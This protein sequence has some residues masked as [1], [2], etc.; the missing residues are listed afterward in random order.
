MNAPDRP[1]MAGRRLPR[2]AGQHLSCDHLFNLGR[3]ETGPV[4]KRL[5]HRAA[6]DRRLHVGQYTPERSKRGSPGLNDKYLFHVTSNSR[7][8]RAIYIQFT[9]KSS[10]FRT[11]F[12]N[13]FIYRANRRNAV[14]SKILAKIYMFGKP[15]FSGPSCIKFNISPKGKRQPRATRHPRNAGR[16]SK[17]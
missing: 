12:Y 5:Y 17:G 8:L 1:R 2:A 16:K 10:A 6:Q 7:N 11:G 14:S 13:I 9:C 4:Q 3:V 15:G